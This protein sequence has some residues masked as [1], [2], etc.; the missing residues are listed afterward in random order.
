MK[1]LKLFALLVL[2]PLVLAAVGVWEHQRADEEIAELAELDANI[3]EAIPRLREI[4][5]RSKTA[6]VTLGDQKVGVLLALDRFENAQGELRTSEALAAA[7]PP[8]AKA[9]IG[10]SVLAALVGALALLATQAAGAIARRSREDLL[11]VFS[12]GRRVLPF[13]LVS[14]ISL[15]ALTV[16]AIVVYEALAIWH[17]G[18]M[19]SGEIKGMVIAALVG[20]VCLWTVWEMLKQLKAMRSMF[21]ATSM[22]VLGRVV[23]EAEAPGLWSH[24]RMLA[25]KLEALP[26]DHIVVGMVDGFYVTANDVLVEPAGTTLRGR[27]LHV[28][29]VHLALMDRAEASAVIGH[30]LGHFAGADTDYSMRF[31]PI[32]DGVGRSLDAVHSS[33]YDADWMRHLIMRPAFLFGLFF[34][35]SFHHAVNHWSREREIAADA[36]G[37]GLAGPEAAGSALV[38]ISST[39]EAVHASI[40]AHMIDPAAAPDD[41]LQA[42]VTDLA[43]TP[44]AM[45][46]T[47][48]EESLP[49]PSDSHPTTLTRI[50]ALGLPLDNAVR[51]GT[52]PVDPAIALAT[53]D[54]YFADAPAL[55]REIGADLKAR[56]AAD[57]A[58]IVEVLEGHA[59]AVQGECRL[60]EGARL[61]GIVL[62]VMGT[63]FLV[64][65]GGLLTTQ[66]WLP[67]APSTQNAQ[68]F[69]YLGA[70]LGALALW[71]IYRGSR[72]VK[73]ADVPALVLTPDTLW[74]SNS[75]APLP[76]AHL[77]DFSLTIGSAIIIRF[78]LEPDAPLPVFTKRKT[79]MPGARLFA[80]KRIIQMMMGKAC[81][82]G[83]QLKAPVLLETLSAYFNSGHARQALQDL[84]PKAQASEAS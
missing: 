51:S 76:I 11:R 12:L 74:F 41:M 77:A 35:E 59:K 38:R 65:A 61:R 64:V 58:E 66:L 82:D 84:K 79:G 47:L 83:K 53:L 80:K 46:S 29:L 20:L 7:R 21:E 30:E 9:V 2:F 23:S 36:A 63:I 69:L 25:Q 75:T 24:V 22:D 26:P 60:H 18:R 8:I 40:T 52:R 37:A 70:A 68:I 28:P 73:Y 39:S 71:L 4:A 10:L 33:I 5:A 16:A 54:G 3:Q 50:G 44:L 48:L 31:L 72:F 1:R 34:M 27:T 57:D 49:H 56:L 32:Y 81:V 14:H 42:V 17:L 6:I 15:T 19:S 13:V 43:G 67:Q 45:P 62:M 55:R 78:M